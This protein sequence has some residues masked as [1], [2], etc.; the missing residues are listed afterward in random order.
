MKLYASW[1]LSFQKLVFNYYMRRVERIVEIV[2][3]I[4]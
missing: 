4:L 1:G 2:F 3:G